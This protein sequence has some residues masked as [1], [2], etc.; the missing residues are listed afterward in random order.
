MIQ[1]VEITVQPRVTAKAPTTETVGLALGV[2]SIVVIIP[3]PG[4]NWEVYTR[5]L[6]LENAIIPDDN[7]QWLPL[8]R[9]PLVF[10]PMFSDWKGIPKVVIEVCSPQAR[11]PHTIQYLF[12][13]SERETERQLLSSL[14]K[15][16]F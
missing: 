7:T 9:N 5:I 2:L 8:E 13:V 3:A 15:K 10:N 6:H 4:P 11:Y 1:H 16:G 14:I 12:E